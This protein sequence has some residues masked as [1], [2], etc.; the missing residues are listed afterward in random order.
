[1]SID[2]SLVLGKEYLVIGLIDGANLGYSATKIS[3]NCAS[4]TVN[5]HLDEPKGGLI[6]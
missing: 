3:I 6:C 4:Y 1:M 2:D 5:L